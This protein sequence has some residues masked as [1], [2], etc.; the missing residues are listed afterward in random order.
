[1]CVCAHSLAAIPLS[2]V[3]VV[4][5]HIHF[6]HWNES[7]SCY[8]DMLSVVSLVRL[9]KVNGINGLQLIVGDVTE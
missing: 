9:K 5:A 4:S 7:N 1:M 6:Q 2:S 8:V 3:P